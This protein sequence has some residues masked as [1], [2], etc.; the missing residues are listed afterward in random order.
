M[1]LPLTIHVLHLTTATNCVSEQ[2]L[3]VVAGVNST[4]IPHFRYMPFRE[5]KGIKTCY[6]CNYPCK[7]V[8]Q[9]TLRW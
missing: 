5:I 3:G 7:H 8:N 2:I 6:Y 9:I 4:D 1:V